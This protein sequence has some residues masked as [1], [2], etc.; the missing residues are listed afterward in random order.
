[1]DEEPTATAR[2]VNRAASAHATAP[3]DG[4]AAGGRPDAET[5]RIA[6]VDP[7]SDAAQACI[8][9][10]LA[11]LD[12]RFDTGF[13]ARRS[14]SADPAELQPPRG[15]FLLATLDGEAIGCG[16]LKRTAPGMGEIKRM[17][18]APTARGRGIA[19]RLLEALETQAASMALHTLRLD[20]NRTLVEAMALYA[21]N[22]YREIAD[23]N[24]NAYADHWFEKRLV[25]QA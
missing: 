21:R 9:A 20:T 12:Q 11:E 15:A 19:Q 23:Y 8:A 17:W 13:D 4:Q 18:V 7:G 14:V 22:G 3:R 6:L 2:R 25:D 5:V 24:G 1:M 10:Y 16:G